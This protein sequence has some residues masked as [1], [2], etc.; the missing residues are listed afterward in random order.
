MAMELVTGAPAAGGGCVA[1][2]DDGRVVFV[3]HSLPGERV[4]AD[5]TSETRSFLRADAVAIL[6]PS[7]D[8]VEPPCPHAGPGRC[9]GCDFQHI[10]L[11][12]QRRL[13]S[14]LVAEQ[15]HRL[16]GVDLPVEIEAVGTG[17][18]SGVSDGLGWR[19]RIRF[20]VDDVG[21]TGFHRHRSHDI[22]LV[23]SCPIASPAVSS[24]GVGA[25]RW[26]GAHHV[27]VT[28]PAAGGTPVVSV[29]TR[30]SGLAATPTIDADLVVDGR[31]SQG[32]GRVCFEVGGHRFEISPGVFWQVHPEAAALL[33]RCVIDGLE[34]R[35]GERAADLYAGAGLFTVP[36]ARAVGRHGSVVA[37]ERSRRACADAT[38]NTRGLDGIEVVRSD[39]TATTVAR[40]LQ[41]RDLVVLDPSR[42]GAGQAVMGALAAI[43]P[44]PRRMA[45]VS[46]DPASFSRDLRVMLDAGWKVRSLRGFDLFPMTEHIELVCILEPPGGHR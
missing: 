28:A 3:R 22:E 4:V 7:P 2:A 44:P 36:L 11:P 17:D 20:A 1:R 13:K 32:S 5:V 37:L 45:Y 26:P 27:E 23:E 9:G 21:R 34:P 19:T 12:A 25:W 31:P 16:A 38:R 43:D 14:S 46:C 42:E 30:R 33:T 35:P 39:V 10:S 40:R 24:V 15:L 29:E 8:R 41:A 18:G 6:E